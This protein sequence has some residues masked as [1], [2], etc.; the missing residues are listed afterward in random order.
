MDYVNNKG[1]KIVSLDVAVS[2][3]SVVTINRLNDV[4]TVTVRDRKPRARF[5]QGRSSVTRPSANSQQYCRR[6][7]HMGRTRIRIR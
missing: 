2:N 6:K 4:T 3:D 1:E 5:R 7:R